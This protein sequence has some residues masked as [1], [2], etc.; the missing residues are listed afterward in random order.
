MDEPL[1]DHYQAL[2]V[3]KSADAAAVKAIYRKLVLKC[4][5]DKVTDPTLKQEKQEEFHKI[6]QA[7]EVLVDDEKRANYDALVTLERMRKERPVRQSEGEKTARFDV[8]TRGGAS[9]RATGPSRYATEERK[10][11]RSY[12]DEHDQYFDDRDRSSRSKYDT[13][14]PTPKAGA[15]PRSGRHEKESSSKSA[16]SDRTRSER[17]KTRDREDRKE[18][19][20]VSAERSGSSSPDE[21][22]RF[23]QEFQKR[24]ADEDARRQA[25]AAR[26]KAEDRRSYED[27]RYASSTSARKMSEQSE[28]AIRYLHKSRAQ[29]EAEIRPAPPVRTSSRDYYSS[30]RKESRPEA[31]RRSSARPKERT[32]S[33]GRGY[34]EIV[35]WDGDNRRTPPSLKASYSSPANMEIPGRAVPQRSYTEA[36][37]NTHASTSPPPAFHRSST[38]PHSSSA[39]TKRAVPSTLRETMTPEHS[40]PEREFPTVPLPQS[41]STKH[42]YYPTASGAGMPLRTEDLAAAGRRTVLREP[43]RHRQR[44]P[45]PLSPL[46]S[47]PPI[48]ANRPS[49]I[50]PTLPRTDSY[51]N[52]SPEERGRSGRTLYG[53]VQSKRTRPSRKQ[54]YD[55][56]SVAFTKSYGEEDVRWADRGGVGGMGMGSKRENERAFANVK[57]GLGRTAT[58]AY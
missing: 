17:T 15:S 27:S 39:R 56:E 32:S 34:P 19:K 8:P 28:D 55:P 25:E 21:K 10:P 38:M 9:F 36:P 12:D 18:R 31:V 44:S 49:E 51:R 37:V 16:K 14:P 30:S 54:S 1:P 11:S 46:P 35:D 48:G 22:T 3:D 43:E 6:Q 5:P 33:S 47:R 7:Y 24:G 58:F 4:H 23:Q 13:Y 29:V 2:G 41:S 52:V 20:F 42:Y 57:P 26:R 40:S 50:R 53:E 45:S